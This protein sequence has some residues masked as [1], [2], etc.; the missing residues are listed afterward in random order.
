M[1]DGPRGLEF[2]DIGERVDLAEL[3]EPPKADC[4][5]KEG[6]FPKVNRRDFLKRSGL[7]AA[8]GAALAAGAL[9]PGAVRAEAPPGAAEWPLVDPPW[10]VPGRNAGEDGG[11]G[12]RSQFETEVRAWAAS[13]TS[14]RTPL[15]VTQGIITPS[16][17]HFERHHSGIPTIDPAQH[18]L[19]IHGMVDR[20]MRYSVSDLR[21]FPS[22]SRILFMECSGNSGG[23]RASAN[24]PNIQLAH[25]LTSTSEWTGVK[26]STLLHQV[27]VQDGAAWIIAEGADGALMNRSIPLDKCM[28]DAFIAYGQNGEAVRPEQGY[29]MRLVLP[30]WEGN[31]N[32]KWLRR[33][34]VSDR[35][36]M[37]REET[38][39]YTDL[40]TLTGKARQFSF[41]MDAK[42]LITFPSGEMRLPGPGFYEITGIAWTGRGKITRVEISTDGGATW[43]LA[44][45]QEPVLSMAHTRFRFPWHWDGQEALLESRATD[46]TGYMQPT[47]AFLQSIRGT[48]PTYHYNGIQTWK[49]LADGSVENAIAV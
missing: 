5:C 29:P 37:T 16:G 27:G 38:S 30:G 42:S 35:P 33:L 8:S 1:D 41:V 6:M 18:R 46:E 20:P 22:M 26:L 19:I 36:Y 17:L 40:I 23:V 7:M 21:R 34:E 44:A 31:S 28:D 3:I 49:V 10:S 15:H 2:Y 4:P 32:I 25:G 48:G 12:T 43:Q 9:T 14:S 45:L 24:V 39:K 11:Y 13:G 47:K